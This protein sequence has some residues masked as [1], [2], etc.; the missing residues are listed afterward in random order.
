MITN[1]NGKYGNAGEIIIFSDGRFNYQRDSMGK[2][3]PKEPGTAGVAFVAVRQ[4]EENKCEAFCNSQ[5]IERTTL[6]RSNLMAGS[7]ALN[8]VLHEVKYG[9]WNSSHTERVIFVTRSPY[10]YGPLANGSIFKWQLYDWMVR[11]DGIIM[12]RLNKDLWEGIAD[13][14]ND[15]EN[16]GMEVVTMFLEKEDYSVLNTLP[17]NPIAL[18]L[19]ASNGTSLIKDEWY[20][21]TFGVVT[22]K[23]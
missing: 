23:G 12:E 15:F 9:D 20:E 3:L 11:K 1:M 21:K 8:G 4:K 10:L 22:Q 13:I 16:I 6:S 19:Q 14:L 18:A 5:G 2:I 17:E 7:F